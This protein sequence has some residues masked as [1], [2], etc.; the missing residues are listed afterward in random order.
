MGSL[1]LQAGVLSRLSA[2]ERS[3]DRIVAYDDQLPLL[4]CDDGTY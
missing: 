4:Q 2:T 3:R 1:R